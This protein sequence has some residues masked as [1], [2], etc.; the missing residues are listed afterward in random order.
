MTADAMEAAVHAAPGGS[1]VVPRRSVGRLGFNVAVLAGSQLVT[2]VM[3]LLWTLVVPRALG[4]VAMG[5]VVTA[6]A[7]TGIMSVLLGLG[8]RNF[9]VKEMAADGTRAPQL[10]GTAIALRVLLLLPS[11]ALMAAYV[12]FAG[13][14]TEESEVVYL[15]AAATMLT[16]LA[17]PLQAG[18]QAIERM[19]YLA[20]ADIFNKSIQSLVGVC[21]ILLGFGAVGLVS[22][23]VVGSAMVLG[24]NFWWMRGH[25]R[26]DLSFRLA[27]LRTLL[28]ESLAY[29]AFGLFYMIYL[30]I[31]TVMLAV[32]APPEV[33]GWY[34]VPTKIFNTLLFIPVILSTA[35]LP[36]LCAAFK[37]GPERLRALAR[38]P[39]ETVIVLS[40][41]VAAGTAIVSG[42]VIHMLYGTAYAQSVPVLA[43]LG[44]CSIP[45]YLN[46]MLSQLLV[47][48]NRQAVWT[49]A[50]VGATV[51]NP[52]LNLALIQYTQARF[53]NGAIGASVSLL[54][55]ETAIVI[56]G[57][58][59]VR[60]VLTLSFLPRLL[61]ALVATAM[62]A[63]VAQLSVPMGLLLEVVIS[64]AVFVIA[65]IVLKVPSKDEIEV[66]ASL[67]ARI[68]GGERVRAF[69]SG[70]A[71]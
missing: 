70:R 9:L 44:F 4:P 33:V 60:G 65:A 55:T 18:F 36:R 32:M 68:G 43:L 42:P 1:G 63:G 5:F 10:M 35:W 62:M 30:W 47:A 11:V 50:M 66:M 28:R 61:R 53:Y 23:W 19:E 34:G 37:D 71:A 2:W 17:E 25:M 24:L 41:P 52:I 51:L 58:L 57:L 6:W 20:Y 67:A 54:L 21:L 15:A 13:F 27:R 12:H 59:L 45:M 29:W 39:I 69:L 8:T 16:L 22:W 49:R 40:L 46:I 3:S 48:S 56:Y 14:G 38:S 7:A 31:D 64:A 26:I